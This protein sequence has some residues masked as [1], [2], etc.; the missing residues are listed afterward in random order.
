MGFGA[1]VKSPG[2]QDLG[3]ILSHV[4]Q[5]DLLRYGIIPE[6]IGRLPVI[7]PLSNLNREDL[8]RIL[9]EPKNA[10]T[11]QY[12][13][14]L[15][16]DGVNLIFE[17]DAL[18]AIADK[19]TEKKIGAR[20]LRSVMESIMTDVMYAVPSDPTIEKVVIT[21]DCVNGDVS[22]EIVHRAEAG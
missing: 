7:T 4:Q 9:T 16:M 3:E 22:P 13:A 1:D 17:R 5:H 6:L 19:A 18:E 10:L 11:K 14:L 12:Q 8:I 20:G 2:A 21:A 15:S